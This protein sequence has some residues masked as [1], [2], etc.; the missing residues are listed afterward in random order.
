MNTNAV[1]EPS[2]R[3]L[4]PMPDGSCSVSATA[5]EALKH[6]HRNRE[7]WMR[8]VNRLSNNV[9]AICRGKVSDGKAS[10]EATALQ[11][12]LRKGKVDDPHLTA[13]AGPLLEAEAILRAHYDGATAELEALTV[14]LPGLAFVDSTPG[15]GR[16]G[17]AQLLAEAGHLCGYSHAWKLWRRFG[18]GAD[19]VAG[20]KLPHTVRSKRRRVVLY[21]VSDALLKCKASPYRALYLAEKAREREQAEAL[22]IRIVPQGQKAACIKKGEDVLTVLQVH[23]RAIRHAEREL[24]SDL[25]AAFCA[26][27]QGS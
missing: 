23:R 10:A 24:L 19:Q 20:G 11:K 8:A 25:W 15:L 1:A 5:L 13:I 2:L 22:G 26:D 4:T 18:V 3:V 7:T 27:C 12:L 17:F 16:L 14:E 6:T 21:R 9:S